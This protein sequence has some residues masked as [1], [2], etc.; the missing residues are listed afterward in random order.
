MERRFVE[1]GV[2][3]FGEN[4][5][6]AGE[7]V[8]SDSIFGRRK[9]NLMP[10]GSPARWAWHTSVLVRKYCQTREML[11][12]EI[13]LGFCGGDPSGD[14]AIWVED[15]EGEAAA[16]AVE[17]VHRHDQAGW[18][19]HGVTYCGEWD[20]DVLPRCEKRVGRRRLR[21]D[22]AGKGPKVRR[23]ED[24]ASHAIAEGRM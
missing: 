13:G 10:S 23:G 14:A 2:R 6:T 11:G 15:A 20:A 19:F 8:G 12:K 3:L 9:R 16:R 18:F 22:S 21:D 5:N 4:V 7:G 17:I 24:A 1:R